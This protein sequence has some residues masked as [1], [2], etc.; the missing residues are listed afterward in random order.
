MCPPRRL[1]HVRVCINTPRVLF[2]ALHPY[3]SATTTSTVQGPSRTVLAT[4]TLQTAMAPKPA[5]TA[6]KAPATTASKAPAKTTTEK[7]AKK[8]TKASASGADGD[9]KK[10]RKGRKETYSSYIYKGA[11]F[12][13]FFK[14]MNKR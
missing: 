3:S 4:F 8:S 7:A 10:R 9:K 14:S 11:H 6:G 12:L 1:G 5:S 13:P 2:C